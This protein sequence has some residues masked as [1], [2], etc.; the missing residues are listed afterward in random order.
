MSITP[1]PPRPLVLCIDDED[2]GLHIRRLL[3]EHAGFSVLAAGTPG[4]ALQLFRENPVSAV[5]TDHLMGRSTGTNLA[6]AM[7]RI[8]P[9]VP[10]ILLSGTTDIPR[11]AEQVDIFVSKTDG[12]DRLLQA[13]RDLTAAPVAEP[14]PAGPAFGDLS[15]QALL[16]AV[17]G[18][19]DDAIFSKTLD[20]TI[21]SWN[22]AAERMYGYRA[23]EI[24]GKPVTMLEA[25]EGPHNVPE[26][27]QRLRRGDVVQHLETVRAGKDGRRVYVQLTIS[28]IRDESGQVIGA[29]TIA[30]DVTQLRLAE[31][32]LRNSEKLAVAGRMAATVA[33]EINNPLEAVSNVLYL[34]Q[35]SDTLG[36]RDRMLVE[37][38]QQELLR[39]TEITRLTLGF[40]RD[41][42]PQPTTMQV[43]DML[44]NVL[45]LYGRRLQNLGIQVERDYRS[46][47]SVTAVPGELR[48][49]FSNLIVNA[50][51]A[52]GDNGGRLMLRVRDTRDWR[53]LSR[54]AVSVLIADTGSGIE[55]QHRH[56]LF[57]P[58]YTTK[59]EKGTG[60]GLWVSRGIVE[61]HGGLIRFRG[62][63]GNGRSG[64][65]FLVL[66]PVDPPA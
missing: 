32:A 21:L 30:R 48:Q 47:G 15:L 22:R 5:V 24:I 6:A 19:S 31:Q 55:P 26:I 8:K 61:K 60:V 10:I 41:S 53:D 49:V 16:A 50:I 25:P 29:S 14:A 57:E 34:L 23:D 63:A 35:H 2:T 64:A 7:K 37:T 40:Y 46:S 54:P 18:N 58:F 52:L 59:G 45:G 56:R 66:L 42:Q 39:V 65:C 51:D 13:L 4:E 12:P 9:A 43:T 44:D 20:G 17:V 28:P 3:L 38:A 1:P 33:H 27:M 62:R 36:E 11:G